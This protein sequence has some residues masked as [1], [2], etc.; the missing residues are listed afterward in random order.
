MVRGETVKPKDI[1]PPRPKPT[2]GVQCSQAPT[3]RTDPKV[4]D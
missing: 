4:K 3:V 2:Q 1:T